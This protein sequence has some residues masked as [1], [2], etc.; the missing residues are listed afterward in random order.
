MCPEKKHIKV[1]TPLASM[2]A[3]FSYLKARW[4]LELSVALVAVEIVLHGLNS[5]KIL[6]AN[7][8]IE[9]VRL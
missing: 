8:V 1:F 3:V 5:C 7:T 9:R 2:E 4:M 6:S